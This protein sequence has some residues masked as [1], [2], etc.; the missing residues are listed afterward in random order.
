MTAKVNVVEAS[1]ALVELWAPC[2][3]GTVGTHRVTVRR[4]GG[5][6]VW[7]AHDHDEF[8]LVWEGRLRISFDSELCVV[9]GP[10]DTFLLRKG[11]LHCEVADVGSRIISVDAS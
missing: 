10:G 8:V 1:E 4:A 5:A 7:H 2:T 6:H 11:V 9:L 3:I